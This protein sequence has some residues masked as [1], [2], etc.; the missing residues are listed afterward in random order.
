MMFVA[1]SGAG[2]YSQSLMQHDKPE[3]R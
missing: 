1:L 2:M 3:N